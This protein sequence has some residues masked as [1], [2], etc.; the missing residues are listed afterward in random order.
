[1][2]SKF[3]ELS[4]QVITACA[5]YILE[6]IANSISVNKRVELRGF[7]TFSGTLLKARMHRNPKTREKVWVEEKLA[8]RFKPSKFLINR[9]NQSPMLEASNKASISRTEV[10]VANYLASH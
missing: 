1:M 3:P 5:N 7:G 10:K 4:N 8:S 6:N 2:N 9:V